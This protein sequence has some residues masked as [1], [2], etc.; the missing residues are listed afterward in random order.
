MRTA[1]PFLCI[2][3][4]LS[5]YLCASLLSGTPSALIIFPIARSMG[6]RMVVFADSPGLLDGTSLFSSL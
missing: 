2:W 1:A 6:R 4:V 3:L 5:C